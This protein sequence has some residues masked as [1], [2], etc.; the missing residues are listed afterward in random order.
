MLTGSGISADHQHGTLLA[1][2][3]LFG[4]LML[5]F[6][7]LLKIE[8]G[9]SIDFTQVTYVVTYLHS[10]YVSGRSPCREG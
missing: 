7:I 8:T 4:L 5:S 2:S 9:F 10:R 1:T 6:L 3:S